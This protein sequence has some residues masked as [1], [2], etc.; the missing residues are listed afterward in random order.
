MTPN[1]N[2]IIIVHLSVKMPQIVIDLEGWEF[3]CFVNHAK[4][5][6]TKIYG[7]ENQYMIDIMFLA[8]RNGTIRLISYRMNPFVYESDI[9]GKTDKGIFIPQESKF[10][11]FSGF[12]AWPDLNDRKVAKRIS[13]DKIQSCELLVESLVMHSRFAFLI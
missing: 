7:N 6:E 12:V 10:F 4:F 8:R 1:D 9:H 5:T 3:V 11:I 13:D 2:Q